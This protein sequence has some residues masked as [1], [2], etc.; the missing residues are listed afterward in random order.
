MK[1]CVDM[2]GVIA[3][4]TGRACMVA[5]EAFGIN[6]T[7]NEVI[8]ARI[9]TLIKD[10]LKLAE[11]ELPSDKEIY[12]KLCPPGFFGSL[13]DYP[14]AV[15]GVKRLYCAGNKIIFLTKPLEW[16]HSSSEKIDWLKKHFSDIEYSVIMVSDMSS[17]Y[18]VQ[19]DCL[20]DDDP[21]ALEKL[22]PYHG[23]CIARPWN[24]EFR[25]KQYEGIVVGSMAAAADWLLENQEFM[26]LPDRGGIDAP[27]SNKS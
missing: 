25:L 23:I 19:C 11:R 2:D 12:E 27:K 8:E 14:D 6:L 1:L 16:R 20:I 22:P 21:R 26:S 10:K 13:N 9:S 24:E 3:N 4:F 15:E 7:Y 18:M 5:S 17:K